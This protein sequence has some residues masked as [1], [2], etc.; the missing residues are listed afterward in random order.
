MI[1]ES[2]DAHQMTIIVPEAKNGPNGIFI[3][4]PDL[5]KVAI[6]MPITAPNM[7]ES[8]IPA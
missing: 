4:L 1:C 8:N 5:V 6:K 3:F 7:K 2:I